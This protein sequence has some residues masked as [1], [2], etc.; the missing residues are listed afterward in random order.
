MVRN[1][2]CF[3][4]VMGSFMLSLPVYAHEEDGPEI[5]ADGNEI[6]HT[7][8]L[9]SYSLSMPPHATVSGY[10][11]V[12]YDISAKG[13]ADHTEVLY[14]SSP[15]FYD[16]TA[17]TA[18]KLRFKPRLKNGEAIREDGSV[19]YF[20]FRLRDIDGTLLRNADGY[21][22]FDGEGKHKGEHHCEAYIS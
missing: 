18:P 17:C 22:Q 10:C 15:V 1:F 14:C 6:F 16:I 20:S 9:R 19:H 2:A 4:S 21:P 11:C 8:F 5:D 7:E 3:I 13:D 12:M